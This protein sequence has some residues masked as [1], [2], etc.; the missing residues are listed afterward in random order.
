MRYLLSTW[1]L[2]CKMCLSAFLISFLLWSSVLKK[3]LLYCHFI[4][5]QEK[6]KVNT[7]IHLVTPTQRSILRFYKRIKIYLRSVWR[8]IGLLYNFATGHPQ[9]KCFWST[10]VSKEQK[11]QL[12]LCFYLKNHEFIH[13]YDSLVNWKGNSNH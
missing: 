7:Y 13:F 11:L 12:W 8:Q 9:N 3:Q 10:I 4:R 5:F 1:L 6:A 2:N